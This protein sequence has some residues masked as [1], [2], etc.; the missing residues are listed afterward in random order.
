[1][2]L[3]IIIGFEKVEKWFSFIYVMRYN[4]FVWEKDIMSCFTELFSI[5]GL[6]KIN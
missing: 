6:R 1:M 2:F 5:N 3:G 4:S